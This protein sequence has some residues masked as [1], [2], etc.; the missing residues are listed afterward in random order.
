MYKIWFPALGYYKDDLYSSIEIAKQ[1]G[2]SSGFQF[3]IVNDFDG[4]IEYRSGTFV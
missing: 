4:G 3:W 1:K 2:I